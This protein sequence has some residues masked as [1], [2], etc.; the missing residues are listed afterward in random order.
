LLAILSGAICDAR[1]GQ[2]L[3]RDEIRRLI[4]GKTVTWSNRSESS[5][6][7]GGDYHYAGTRGRGVAVTGGGTYTIGDGVVCYKFR[8]GRL[9][10][11]GWYRDES[12]IYLVPMN[13]SESRNPARGIPRVM[14]I[15]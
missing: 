12:G 4:V 10:C 9:R 6:G 13:S 3:S 14:S 7:A 15:N 8:S 1:A 2:R 5:F 11:D